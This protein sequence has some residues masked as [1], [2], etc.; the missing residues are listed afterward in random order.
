MMQEDDEPIDREAW[1]R[2]LT[3]GAGVPPRATDE[4]I[5]AEA[6]RALAPHTGRWWLPASLAASLLLAVVIVQWQYEAIRSPVPVT[7]S[8]VA[9]AAVPA[10]A[11]PAA[12]QAASPAESAAAASAAVEPAAADAAGKE[13]S[14]EL[15]MPEAEALREPAGRAAAVPAQDAAAPPV[16]GLRQIGDLRS[17]QEA[18]AKP[19]AP[20]QWYAEIEALRAAGRDA[21][22]DAELARLEEAY[23]GWLEEHVPEDR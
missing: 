2:V 20:E 17:T 9:P 15:P 6:R 11:S 10:P 19:R 14:A 16:T 12:P 5:R 23:P 21:E 7:E 18:A 1:R 3:R 13:A 4:R 8:D 22:A